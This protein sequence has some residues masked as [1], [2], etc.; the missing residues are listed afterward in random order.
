MLIK[1]FE[2]GTK[3]DLSF[4]VDMTHQVTNPQEATNKLF[5]NEGQVSG[6]QEGICEQNIKKYQQG[7]DYKSG[8]S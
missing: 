2:K 1:F 3:I 7:D 6:G 8:T 5:Y 4:H